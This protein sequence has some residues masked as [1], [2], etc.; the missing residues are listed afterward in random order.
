MVTISLEG[1]I[2]TWTPRFISSVNA[3]KEED[4][5]I[6]FEIQWRVSGMFTLPANSIPT[7]LALDPTCI[8]M[9]V[10]LS[11]GRLMQ[12]PVPGLVESHDKK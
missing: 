6:S 7:S 1:E 11:D 5:F 10:G 9:Y 2:K 4:L 3:C 12:Y 8:S